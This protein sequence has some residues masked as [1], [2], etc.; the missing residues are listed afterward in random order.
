MTRHIPPFQYDKPVFVKIPF[1]ANGKTLER[2][3]VF[4]WKERSIAV[5]RVSALYYADYLMHNEELEQIMT[6]KIVG[7]G[8]RDMSIEALHELVEEIN[9][10]V[11]LKTKSVD[12][13]N[14]KKCVKSTIKD[15]QIGKIRYWRQI[16][17]HME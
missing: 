6:D 12:E 16:Y 17:G 8:L 13:F 15:K 10:K 9:G 4:K 7:D 11:K 3:Q 1:Y 2:G 14:H 5:D